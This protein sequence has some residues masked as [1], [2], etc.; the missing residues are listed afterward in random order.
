MMHPATPLGVAL[1]IAASIAVVVTLMYSGRRAMPFVRKLG[2]TQR[3]LQLHVWAG[4]LFVAMFLG[5]TAFR[6]PSTPFY[7]V[8]WSTTNLA[9]LSGLIGL[10]LQ[11]TIPR[12]L[13]SATS[14]EV[15]LHRIPEL[16]ADLH[17]RSERL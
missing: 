10:A 13:Q 14:I 4:L 5:H 11:R 7:L 1:G 2:P 9:V 8:L 12:V 6:L 3:Y 17:Q 16:V 15:N